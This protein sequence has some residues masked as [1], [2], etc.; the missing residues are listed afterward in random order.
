MSLLLISGKATS[1]KDEFYSEIS[2]LCELLLGKECIR[3]AFAD[4]LKKMAT[5]LFGWDGNKDGEGRL[6]LIDIGM[7]LRGEYLCKN[8]R[9]F[10]KNT[11][12]EIIRGSYHIYD[13][14]T[15]LVSNFTPQ[16]TFWVDL[17]IKT[18][19]SYNN[20]NNVY[21]CTDWRFKNEFFLLDMLFDN[22]YKIRINREHINYIDNFSEC[23][24]DDFNFDFVI[25][26]DSTLENFHLK[27]KD[28][29]NKIFHENKFR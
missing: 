16:K 24:L 7:I 12:E 18:L 13:V 27:I 28:V 22:I 19:I 17:F 9:I 20:D 3:I 11:M 23:D 2:S 6:L 29:F 15:Y 26:N 5:S 21:V 10:N 8:Y 1:G 14:Y 25:K 4:P